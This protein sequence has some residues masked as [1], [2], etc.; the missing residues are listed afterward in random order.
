MKIIQI[1][2]NLNRFNHSTVN[3]NNKFDRIAVERSILRIYTIK[4]KKK[5]YRL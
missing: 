3:E 2:E 4:K 1:F 5:I